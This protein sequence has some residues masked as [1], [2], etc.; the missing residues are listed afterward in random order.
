[1]CKNVV[2]YAGASRY[3]YYV[4]ERITHP[5]NSFNKSNMASPNFFV[6]VAMSIND[7]TMVSDGFINH[8]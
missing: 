8:Q 3:V 7:K 1:M 2:R 5:T 4:F 6:T